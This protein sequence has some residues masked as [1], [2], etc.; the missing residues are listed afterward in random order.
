[1]RK[2]RPSSPSE[3]ENELDACVGVPCDIG[4]VAS[5]IGEISSISFSS[6]T[7]TSS[8][9]FFD[10]IVFLVGFTAAISSD[11]LLTKLFDGDVSSSNKISLTAAVISA[12]FK[13]GST[14]PF[15]L[16]AST[17]NAFVCGF[18]NVNDAAAAN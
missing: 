18:G 8:M 1:M 12:N 11:V 5:K 16:F 17:V 14:R 2:S 10:S 9:H 15:V 6:S 7:M 4:V 13:F 3:N